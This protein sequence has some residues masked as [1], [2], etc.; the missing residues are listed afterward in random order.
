MRGTFIVIEGLDRC[1]KS[2]QAERLATRLGALL[3][4]FPDR[5]TPIGQI[6]NRY[7]TSPD[8]Q[9]DVHAAHLL[10]LA[11]RWECASRLEAVLASGQHVV[12]D[13]YLYSGVAYSAAQGLDREWCCQSDRGLLRPDVVLFLT[14]EVGELAGRDGFGEERY[15]RRD[16]QERVRNEFEAMGEV[17]GEYWKRVDV[18]GKNVEEV[19]EVIQGVLGTVKVSGEVHR[20]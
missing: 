5:T 17:E 19:E 8:E 18:K 6:I 7:L 10:F 12:A 9:L 4:K 16:L 2:T 13:R 14:N 3:V 15:E 11:N 1:G 20:W